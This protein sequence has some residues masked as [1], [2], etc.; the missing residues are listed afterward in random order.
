MCERQKNTEFVVW[1][2]AQEGSGPLFFAKEPASATTYLD[3][4]KL[5]ILPQVVELHQQSSS[6]RMIL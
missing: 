3:I 4:L 5:F 1:A 2:N 6:S